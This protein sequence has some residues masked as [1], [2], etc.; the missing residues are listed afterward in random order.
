MPFLFPCKEKP[1]SYNVLRQACPRY[2]E[3]KTRDSI[4]CRILRGTANCQLE[5]IGYIQQSVCRDAEI[6]FDCNQPRDDPRDDP[7]PPPS[8]EEDRPLRIGLVE[9][10]YAK[11]H[12]PAT[13]SQLV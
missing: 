11:P 13:L 1:V 8:K 3:C 4:G 7:R 6:C 12:I 5:S 2:A 9:C 10:R